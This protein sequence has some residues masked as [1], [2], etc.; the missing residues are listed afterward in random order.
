MAAKISSFP[1]FGDN[2]RYPSYACGIGILVWHL[3]L[4][5]LYKCFDLHLLN[6][7]NTVADGAFIC[8]LCK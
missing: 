8:N 7:H 4:C 1:N 2:Y 6:H 5:I 3:P